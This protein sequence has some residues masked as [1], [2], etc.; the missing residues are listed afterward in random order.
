MQIKKYIHYLLLLAFSTL[1]NL[2][3][4]QFET[5]LVLPIGHISEVKK[6]IYSPSGDNIAT[7]SYDGTVKIWDSETGKL[8][9]NFSGHSPISIS[10]NTL[11]GTVF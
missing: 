11:L 3:Q 4:A 5:E 2:T 10:P 7:A 8:V 1:T 6:V 9:R